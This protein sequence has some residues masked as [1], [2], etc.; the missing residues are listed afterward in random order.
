MIVIFY[1]LN[2]HLFAYFSFHKFYNLPISQQFWLLQ[3]FPI[4]YNIWITWKI[5]QYIN[6]GLARGLGS[7]SYAMGA[8]I[9]SQLIGFLI[10]QCCCL[11]NCQHRFINSSFIQCHLSNSRRNSMTKTR[12]YI[13]CYKNIVYS[14]L[15]FS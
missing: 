15:H 1:C 14:F 10:Q 8:I 11:H 4:F 5:S 12:K 2:S 7:I 3:W 6:F 9:V 13:L